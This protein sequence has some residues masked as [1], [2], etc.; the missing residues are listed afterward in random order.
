MS[1]AAI[2]LAAGESTRMGRPKALLP[3]AGT[4]L[5]E[6][7]VGQLREAGVSRVVVVLGHEAEAVRPQVPAEAQVVVNERYAEGRASSLRTGAKALPDGADPIVVLGVDQPRPA[8]LMRELLEA[9]GERGA[10]ITVPVVEGRR[11]HPSVVAGTLLG[12]LR[13]AEEASQGLRGVIASHEEEVVEVAVERA[14]AR[15]DLN[16]PEEYEAARAR[17]GQA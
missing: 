1:S 8:A 10:A 6:Y 3:W 4:T 15:L 16:T 5:I 17:F 2:L 13:R 12:E 9:H 11:G 7:Q 14:E